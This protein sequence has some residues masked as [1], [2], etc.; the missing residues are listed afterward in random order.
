M[1]HFTQYVSW[2]LMIMAFFLAFLVI[3]V[4]PPSPYRGEGRRDLSVHEVRGLHLRTSADVEVS[5]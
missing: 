5:L 2:S 1:I 3:A 4:P